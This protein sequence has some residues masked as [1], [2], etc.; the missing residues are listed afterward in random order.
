MNAVAQNPGIQTV[1]IAELMEVAAGTTMEA[2]VQQLEAL[3]DEKLEEFYQQKAALNAKIAELTAT[4]NQAAIDATKVQMSNVDHEIAKRE[5]NMGLIFASIGQEMG[6]LQTLKIRMMEDS[7]EDIQKRE[8][9]AA[10]LE[11]AK[12]VVIN[13]KA[14]TQAAEAGKVTAEA[15]LAAAEGVMG[16]VFGWDA[17]GKGAKV[18]IAK[19]ALE[20]IQ[21]TIADGPKML[22]D[23][24]EVL[25]K[26]DKAIASVE[27][28]IKVDKDHRLKS[29]SLD[30][31]YAKLTDAEA[32]ISKIVH[33]RLESL[34]RVEADTKTE[35]QFHRDLGISTAEQL[36][37]LRTNIAAD[38]MKLGGMKT[39]LAD[40]VG[41][42]D[43]PK[44]KKL[45]NEANALATKLDGMEAQKR[46]AEGKMSTAQV[47][48]TGL[49]ASMRA[50]NSRT[51]L[52]SS[53]FN[54]FQI[55]ASA[56]RVEGANIAELLASQAEALAANSMSKGRDALTLAG[57]DTAIANENA[58]RSTMAD[59]ARRRVALLDEMV[60]RKDRGGKVAA[61]HDQRYAE[62]AA[63]YRDKY[64]KL[65]TA[66]GSGGDDVPK[67]ADGGGADGERK[68]PSLI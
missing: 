30:Q 13:I 43:T 55:A 10:T 50:I 62:S 60:V 4:G 26:A 35:L 48:V 36:E 25:T 24:E 18:T 11:G 41:Q 45:E 31:F 44:Y 1:D 20:E 52:L 3:S 16:P 54:E 46:L 64:G 39:N 14:A 49:E 28:E 29:L 2:K 15:G 22:A 42:E 8:R 59:D 63:E 34:G 61:G 17:F 47:K 6:M 9:A 53:N 32:R 40:M 33:A 23:A 58:D 12:Q 37:S 67:K 7:P 57:L 19:A 27:E 66:G 5:E 56:A 21:K 68:R 51:L 38:E 65:G